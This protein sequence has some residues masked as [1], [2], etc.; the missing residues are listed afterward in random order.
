MSIFEIRGGPITHRYLTNKPK[1]DLAHMYLALL[2]HRNE[3]Q[4]QADCDHHAV[5]DTGAY[6]LYSPYKHAWRC[7]SVERGEPKT[8][9]GSADQDCTATGCSA[10]RE[11]VYCESG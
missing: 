4:K 5:S 2:A 3:L 1:N 10:L 11:P 8:K 6:N 7:D 9:A